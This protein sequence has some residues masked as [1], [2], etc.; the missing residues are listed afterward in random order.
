[1][2][3]DNANRKFVEDCCLRWQNDLRAYLLGVLR[4]REFVE[5]AYQRTVL[6]ALRSADSVRP[7]TVRGWLFRIALNEA[8]QIRRS[9]QRQNGALEQTDQYDFLTVRQTGSV[10]QEVFQREFLDAL[11]SAIERLPE[12]QKEVIEARLLNRQSFATIARELNRPLGTVLTWMHRGLQRL[13]DDTGLK[14]HGREE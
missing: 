7:E 13:R 9:Q 4:R 5:D 6:Q 11:A 2:Q 3:E 1:L 10:E 12:G 14:P 8:R